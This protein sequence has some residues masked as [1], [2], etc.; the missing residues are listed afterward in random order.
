[1]K[2]RPCRTH[3]PACPRLILA[4]VLCLGLLAWSGAHV[5]SSHRAESLNVLCSSIEEL[6]RQWADTFT[7]D[8]GI[9]VTVVRLSSREALSRMARGDAAADYDIWH[10]GPS[11]LYV[12][13]DQRGLLRPHRPAEAE[14]VPTAYR[15]PAGAWTGVYRGNL[16]F[17]SDPD[18]LK[19]LGVPVPQSWEDLLDPRLAG[20]ISSPNPVTSG[21]GST[22]VGVQAHRFGDHETAL[23]WLHRL[24]QNVL[25]YTR[26]GMAPAGVVARGEAAV[27]LTFT[28]HC[29]RQ[30]EVGRRL[31][32]S[33]PREGTGAEIGAVA[34]LKSARHPE[35]AGVYVDF[36][37]SRAGQFSRRGERFPQLPTRT[38]L[39]VDPRL[40]LTAGIR[41]F[42]P[43]A[44]DVRATEKL[45]AGFAAEVRP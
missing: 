28:Q 33:Y 45:V 11:E 30:I 15:D 2:P 1:M 38:D 8:T 42:S 41:L 20:R 36:A 29:V 7:E 9:P 35:W 4:L 5:L 3:P 27:A 17:C 32:I 25:Q 37:T 43:Q 34:V 13:A 16:G 23:A 19:D 24:D 21:T 22:I 31:V 26:S 6:C 14:T 18:A 40:E 39:A 12:L 44:T 10:G